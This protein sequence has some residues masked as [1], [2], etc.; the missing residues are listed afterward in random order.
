MGAKLA[1]RRARVIAGS[2]TLASFILLGIVC[3]PQVSEISAQGLVLEIEAQ[4]ILSEESGLPQARVLIAV[5]DTLQ[6]SILLPPP[7][8]DIG[9]FIP[10]K[11]GHAWN[12]E[13][14]Y[15]LDLEKW[16]LVG[17]S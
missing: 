16:L 5:G 15:T 10:L 3:R 6:T 4:G 12:G 8:P 7:V 11:E 1:T 13:R 14:K 17:P 2:A 9:H